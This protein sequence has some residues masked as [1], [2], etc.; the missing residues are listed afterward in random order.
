M[1]ATCVAQGHEKDG[2]DALDGVGH[3]VGVVL[4]LVALEDEE[5]GLGEAHHEDEEHAAEPVRKEK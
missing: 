2:E 4:V 3:G 1:L 5:V